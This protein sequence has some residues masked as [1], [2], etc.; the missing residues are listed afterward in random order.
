MQ[1][2]PGTLLLLSMGLA[3]QSP[4]RFEVV[5]IR[6]AAAAANAGTSVNL[7]EAGRLPITNEPA[8]LLLRLAFQMQDTQIAGGPPWLDTDRFDIEAKTGCGWPKLTPAR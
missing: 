5:S 7:F 8:K 6:P 2:T 3:A 1:L 4:E